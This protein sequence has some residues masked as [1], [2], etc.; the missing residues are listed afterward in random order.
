MFLEDGQID[1]DKLDRKTSFGFKCQENPLKSLE[2]EKEL[3][4]KKLYCS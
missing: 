2:F 4:A 1:V 3:K